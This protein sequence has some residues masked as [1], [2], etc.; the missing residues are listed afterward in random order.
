MKLVTEND[1]L[2]STVIKL[3]K[4]TQPLSIKWDFW[5]KLFD[6]GSK[7]VIIIV[8]TIIR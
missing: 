7:I 8:F 4:N 1:K 6:K 2:E 3:Y 5:T